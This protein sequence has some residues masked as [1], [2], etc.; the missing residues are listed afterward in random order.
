MRHDKF[1]ESNLPGELQV[2]ASL[3]KLLC[4]RDSARARIKVIVMRILNLPGN[5]PDLQEEATKNV[6]AQA[7]LL[8][9]GWL[10][11]KSNRPDCHN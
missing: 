4:F 11:K 7:D 10:E 5:P 8:H 6:L 9:V 1:D 2:I 3:H